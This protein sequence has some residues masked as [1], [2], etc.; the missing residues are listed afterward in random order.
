MKN[1]AASVYETLTGIIFGM[2]FLTP[3][4]IEGETVLGCSTRAALLQRLLCGSETIC[5]TRAVD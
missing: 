3:V 1:H 5:R 4:P 2:H